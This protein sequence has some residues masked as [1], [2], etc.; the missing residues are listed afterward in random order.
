[1]KQAS[2][3]MWAQRFGLICGR[4][5]FQPIHRNTRRRLAMNHHIRPDFSHSVFGIKS[6]VR[7]REYGLQIV[8]VGSVG[9]WVCKIHEAPQQPSSLGKPAGWYVSWRSFG[10]PATG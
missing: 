3:L 8:H 5:G 2:A 4:H 7:S 10:I 6:L 1:M 9:N